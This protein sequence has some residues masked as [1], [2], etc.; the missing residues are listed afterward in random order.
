MIATLNST[1]IFANDETARL[2]AVAS[3]RWMQVVS[4][5]DP[6][7]GGVSTVVPQ[8]G[9]SL[10][11]DE[12]LTVDIASFSATD[13]SYSLAAFPEIS[14]T[15]W[16]A[17]RAAWILK[18]QLRSRFR[19]QL[20]QANGLHV[21]GLWETHTSVTT[22]IARSLRTPYVLSAHGMLEPW[23]LANKGLK[24]RLY[25]AFIERKN[26]ESAACLHALTLAEAEDY[27]RF[28]SRRPIAVIPN[29]VALPATVDRSH[30]LDKFP[31]LRGKRAV[32]FLGRMHVKKGI[33]LLVKAWADVAKQ[34][35]DA[36]LVL[37]GPDCENTRAALESMVEQRGMSDRVVFTGMLARE[38]KWSAL[39]SAHSF[40]L[41]SYSE[42]LSVAV[43]EAMGMGLPVIV[44]DRC[45]LPEVKQYG[46]GWQ[47][48]ANVPDLTSALEHMLSNGAAA[49]AEIGN[50]GRRL[51]HD[52]F[53][54]P[55][56][57][58][59]MAELYRWVLGGPRPRSFELLE[60][61]A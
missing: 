21:H 19:E 40:V 22:H 57:A 50:R 58:A 18:A 26:I 14:G 51:V 52:R 6:R 61:A 42:G 7:Y 23:A 31:Q 13:E 17:S 20:T 4:H 48:A 45:H 28:G 46:A 3:A 16:P 43:L 44:S 59:Q 56:V 30:F 34:F 47:I 27:R 53:V 39:A 35:P 41:P 5:L 9:T 32:L 1:S 37:A 12:S 10:A 33:D 15:H 29:G 36:V 55:V 8:L 11:R 38:M 49:N 25:S 60:V 24:K 2:A 54:W